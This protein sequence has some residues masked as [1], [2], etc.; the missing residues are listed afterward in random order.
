MMTAATVAY[1]RDIVRQWSLGAKIGE[2]QGISKSSPVVNPSA[3]QI[4]R[5]THPIRAVQPIAR[6]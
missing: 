1:V 2:L 6:T 5:R 4:A 3:R